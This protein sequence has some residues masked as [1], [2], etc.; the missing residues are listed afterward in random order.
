MEE[1]K[2]CDVSTVVR[3]ATS[4][5]CTLGAVAGT[6][7]NSLRGCRYHV[8]KSYTLLYTHTTNNKP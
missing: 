4:L 8:L 6:K 7:K 2:S 1:T 5:H 3:S